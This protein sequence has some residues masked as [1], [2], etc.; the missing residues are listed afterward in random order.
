MAR[1]EGGAVLTPPNFTRGLFRRHARPLPATV[2]GVELHLAPTEKN[3]GG[4]LGYRE[5]TQTQVVVGG[6]LLD[7]TITVTV[8]LNHTKGVQ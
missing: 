6:C 7:A 1:A 2:A 3:L 8:T 4:S 5:Q